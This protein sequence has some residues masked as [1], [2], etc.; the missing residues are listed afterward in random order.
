MKKTIK[1]FYIVMLASIMNAAAAFSEVVI[2]NPENFPEPVPLSL[3]ESAQLGKLMPRTMHLLESSTPENPKKVKIA[4][5]GQSLSD[6]NNKWWRTLSDALKAAYPNADIDVNCLGVGG[7]ASSVLWRTTYQDIATY[8]PDLVIFHVLGHHTYYETILRIIRG[9]TTAE[10]LIQTDHLGGNDGSGSGCDWNYDLTNMSTWENKMSFQTIPGYCKTYGLERDNRRQEWYDY[11]KENC[12]TPKSGT[13]LSDD[14]HFAEQGN[15]LTAALTAR[16]FRYYAGDN[17]DPNGMVKVYKVG[18]DVMVENDSIKLPIEGNRIDI[19]TENGSGMEAINTFIDGKKPSEFPGCYN[20]TRASGGGGFWSGGAVQTFGTSPYLEEETWTIS[21]DNS[22]NFTLTGTETGEDG[23]GNLNSRFESN[24]GKIVIRSEDW[25]ASP[26]NLTFS[27]ETKLYAKDT[28]ILPQTQNGENENLVTLAQGFPNARH[29][30][31]MIGAVAKIKE[32]RVYKPSYKLALETTAD[33]TLKFSKGRSQK[34]IT[35]NTNTYWQV[36]DKTDWITVNAVDNNTGNELLDKKTITLTVDENTTGEKR[37]AEIILVGVGVEPVLLNIT[38]SAGYAITVNNGHA[39]FSTATEG[40]TVTIIA[41]EPEAGKEFKEWTGDVK[42]VADVTKPET[43]LTMPGKD[44]VLTATYG[45]MVGIEN[46]EKKIILY[47]N[48]AENIVRLQG[49]EAE[50]ILILDGKGTVIRAIN[51][52]NGE[53]ID[54]AGLL[55]GFYILKTTEATF[56]FVKK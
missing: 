26:R 7:F 41:D 45:D 23:I 14:I 38:Q 25:W 12:Y 56:S 6:G 17:H 43:T 34:T 18:T 30:I 24:S 31:C 13:L 10:M 35:V 55:P 8:Y 40:E 33:D 2:P 36:Y 22:Q 11:L 47:P 3:E 19:I 51:N 46:T 50:S 42:S 52:Y 15:Y 39:D 5:Y 37:N 20:N 53:P 49:V 9:C 32:I 29:E 27:F 48:P 21:I 16:H 4:I 44:I 54:I 1:T 28:Y